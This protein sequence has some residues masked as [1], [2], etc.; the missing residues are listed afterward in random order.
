MTTM[1]EELDE[2]VGYEL[3]YEQVGTRD[4]RIAVTKTEDVPYRFICQ[5]EIDNVWQGSGTLVGPQT[6]LTAAHVIPDWAKAKMRIIPGRRGSFEPF[7]SAT[8]ASFLR[9]DPSS[10]LP[11]KDLG[12]I[13]LNERIG[14]KVGWWAADHFRRRAD[15]RGTSILRGPLPMPAGQLKVHLS[16]YPGDKPPKCTRRTCGTVQYHTYDDT[17]TRKAGMLHYN[18][19]TFRGHSGSPVW[20]KRHASNGGHV[21]VGIHKGAI[22]GKEGNW[23]VFID[24]DVRKFITDNTLK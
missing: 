7:G 23:A 12:L 17:V 5:I 14:T 24:A 11:R 10:S 22:P 3:D 9:M 8:V 13:Q 2:V 16:G 15:P 20:V 6:V 18:N 1:L 4:T 19:D 21:M